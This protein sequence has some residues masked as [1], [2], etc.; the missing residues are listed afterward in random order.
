MLPLVEI[1]TIAWAAGVVHA[2]ILLVT[3]A[4]RL[5][6]GTSRVPSPPAK[7]LPV[8]LTALASILLAA[9]A[10]IDN[11]FIGVLARVVG[12]AGL[13]V[14]VEGTVVLIVVLPRVTRAI[15]ESPAGTGAGT[16]Q[17]RAIPLLLALAVVVIV[18]HVAI[19]SNVVAGPLP[20]KPGM[21]AHRGGS[22]AG[23][24]NTI[25][26]AATSH[27]LG[28]VG[29]EIDIRISHD[30]VPFLLH[31]PTFFRT[32][33]VATVFPGRE[34]DRAETFTIAEILQL[35]AG[36]SFFQETH[37]PWAMAT[38]DPAVLEAYRQA[39]V[40]T[41]EEAIIVT[42]AYGWMVDADMKNPPSD[43]PFASQ[44]EDIV[45]DMLFNSSIPSIMITER[46]DLVHANI[47][48]VLNDLP[49]DPLQPVAAG[50]DV[51]KLRDLR[52]SDDRIRLHASE[53]LPIYV[54][55]L[56]DILV[57]SQM[58]C[59]GV[60]YVMTDGP[61]YFHPLVIPAWYLPAPAW[62]SAWAAVQVLMVAWAVACWRR[63][64][65]GTSPPGLA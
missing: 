3:G 53:G 44:F 65:K 48:R 2:T 45:F 59:L 38:L 26:V 34:H 47:T 35:N 46:L 4:R 43:H 1:V 60:S 13:L 12:F 51:V 8:I 64:G 52:T 15:K 23:P 7:V 61:Q 22:F 32:T 54:N 63:A 30:G 11:T 57:F 20:A 25:A 41:L 21:I 6:Q 18:P 17:A 58:W 40:A 16:R 37:A 14:L 49:A 27:A 50:Y 10:I 19:P 9:P 42:E 29:W 5:R 56:N 33:D 24:E 36:M 28:A 39:T 62:F 31:D 55:V